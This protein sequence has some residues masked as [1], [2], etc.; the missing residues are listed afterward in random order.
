MN[1]FPGALQFNLPVI[2]NQPKAYKYITGNRMNFGKSMKIGKRGYNLE[3]HIN[4]TYGISAK[5]DTLPT[6]LTDE[7]QDPANERTRVP[8]AKL[9]K[10]YYKGRGWDKN[11]IPK[12]KTLN[13]LQ[14]K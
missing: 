11:G 9:K 3:R 4:T 7:L 14:I 2:Y 12:E 1:K 8:L 6:R 5:D 13:K 10:K